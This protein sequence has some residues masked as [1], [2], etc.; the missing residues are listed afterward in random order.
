MRAMAEK[1]ERLVRAV[2]VRSWPNGLTTQEVGSF[3]KITRP[4]TTLHAMH[5]RGIVAMGEGGW[6]LAPQREPSQPARA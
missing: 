2:L 4:G 1:R 5:K 3:A 6:R